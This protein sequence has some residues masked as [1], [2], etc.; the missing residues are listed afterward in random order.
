MRIA[1]LSKN[2]GKNGNLDNLVLAVLPFFF[3]FN[4]DVTGIDF[5]KL[6][7][8]Q[9][10]IFTETRAG[11]VETRTGGGKG[12]SYYWR[13]VRV[14]RNPVVMYFMYRAYWVALTRLR[15]KTSGARDPHKQR[16]ATAVERHRSYS[17]APR[18]ETPGQLH[19]RESTTFPS[20][21]NHSPTP[22]SPG[23]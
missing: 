16:G 2:P 23:L 11:S 4:T 9:A 3:F 8:T 18:Q 12:K 5:L 6:F 19:R 20:A 21:A 17:R 22:F 7:S 13:F 1:F 15:C 14:H 10:Q